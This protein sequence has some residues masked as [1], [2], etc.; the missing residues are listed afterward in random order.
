VAAGCH[1]AATVPCE[2]RDAMSDRIEI[3]CPFCGEVLELHVEEDLRGRL[4]QD[5]E[6]CC[7]PIQ[8]DVRRDEWGDP[9]VSV[10]RAD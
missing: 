3:Q 1:S 2:D 7:N 10:E 4:V 5:C 6:V 9:V 8:L